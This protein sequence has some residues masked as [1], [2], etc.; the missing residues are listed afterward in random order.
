MGKGGICSSPHQ[1]PEAPRKPLLLGGE[2]QLPDILQ[3]LPK[4]TQALHGAISP[5]KIAESVSIG[6]I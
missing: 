5:K 6:G 1:P 3:N 2:A 4:C